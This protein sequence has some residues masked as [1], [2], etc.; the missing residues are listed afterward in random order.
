MNKLSGAKTY[1]NNQGQKS[2]KTL[3]QRLPEKVRLESH[4]LVVAKLKDKKRKK[5]DLRKYLNG[6]KCDYV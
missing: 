3:Q 6:N 4:G 5:E 2:H 1:Q